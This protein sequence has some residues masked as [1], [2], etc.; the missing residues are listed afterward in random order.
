MHK[1]NQIKKSLE[2]D[3][4][5]EKLRNKKY[6]L[7][8]LNE[9]KLLNIYLNDKR[10]TKYKKEFIKSFINRL[11]IMD[12]NILKKYYYELNDIC[13]NGLNIQ[14]GMIFDI[15]KNMPTNTTKVKNK[16]EGYSNDAYFNQ[17]IDNENYDELYNI[18][19]LRVIERDSNLLDDKTK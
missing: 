4:V 15:D 1:I 9:K 12:E 2:D 19:G 11:K 14:I 17:L 6:N 7:L 5:L 16:P 8:S 3:E 18:Y 10:L 13:L